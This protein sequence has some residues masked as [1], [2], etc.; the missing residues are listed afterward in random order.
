MERASKGW[1]Y[2]VCRGRR[3]KLEREKL[4]PGCHK[5]LRGFAPPHRPL[6]SE[7]LKKAS[8]S[9]PSPAARSELGQQ[10]KPRPMR[11]QEVAEDAQILALAPLL[12]DL[13]YRV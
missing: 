9:V 12:A 1:G 8:G 11:I 5:E 2:W 7:V 6:K 3:F 13:G 4:A 10:G